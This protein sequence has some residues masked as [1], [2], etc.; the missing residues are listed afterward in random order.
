M[1]QNRR[2]QGI[3]YVKID[4][5]KSP[6]SESVSPNQA[7]SSRL[8]GWESRLG[9]RAMKRP[10]RCL[11]VEI[12]SRKREGREK[13]VDV[14]SGLGGL[15]ILIRFEGAGLLLPQPPFASEALQPSGNSVRSV[16]TLL[17]Y[18]HWYPLRK[19]TTAIPYPSQTLFPLLQKA[20]WKEGTEGWLSQK[21]GF[22]QFYLEMPCP[23]NVPWT[24]ES[25]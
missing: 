16:L 17:V 21:D 6:R 23:P 8:N 9:G 11:N 19:F 18:C 10:G 1:W 14:D 13:R 12:L 7:C 25:S 15:L 5:T 4:L 2:V 24:V 3:E 22:Q 20:R